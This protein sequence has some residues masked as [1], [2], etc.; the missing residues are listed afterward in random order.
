MGANSE[1]VI[2]VGITNQALRGSFNSS[3]AE[4]QSL[5]ETAGGKVVG[6]L[7]QSQVRPY[8]A[9][10]IGKGKIQ[11]LQEIAAAE[12]ADLI[13]FDNELT[14][15][16]LR[17]LEDSLDI[18]IIDRTML[19]LDIFSQRARSREGQLQVEVA[20]LAYR[21]PRLTG[22]GNELSRLGGIGNRGAGEQK[23]ELDKRYLRRRIKD[24]KSQ[25]ERIDKTRELHRRRRERA[26][27]RVVSLV[28]YTNA[29]KSSLFNAIC[30]IG[31]S[32]G[33]GAAEADQRLFQT[34]DTTTR[35]ISGSRGNAFLITDTVGFIQNLPHHLVQ[36]FRSTLQEAAQADII[37]HVID[38]ADPEYQ[39][40]IEVVDQVLDELGADRET[41]LRVFTKSDLL[42]A[43][44]L[45]AS[46]SPVVSA[47]TGQGIQLLL[48][49]LTRRLGGFD[50]SLNHGNKLQ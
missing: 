7:V 20:M 22:K 15:I 38:I 25:I 23:L 40:K 47:H 4:L 28:G 36:A 33:Q 32:S 12:K 44:R 50:C 6:S 17:N 13:V 24:I 29:G 45:E 27:L 1:R 21:L 9:T 3:F 43:D 42:L 37:L 48:D 39:D 8:S 14:P 34:L 10:Y 19:I 26:G 31:H 46:G 11:E 41:I 16:Q 5:V 18:R 30:R 49:T 35:R 2:T